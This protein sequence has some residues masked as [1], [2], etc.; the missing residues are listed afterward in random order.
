M[1]QLLNASKNK[2]N[3]ELSGTDLQKM[4][5]DDNKYEL[6]FIAGKALDMPCKELFHLMIQT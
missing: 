6:L 3:L 5:D 2:V 4:F 1:I